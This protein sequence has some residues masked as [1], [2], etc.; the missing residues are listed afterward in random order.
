MFREAHRRADDVDRAQAP[1]ERRRAWRRFL[2][3]ALVAL[4]EGVLRDGLIVAAVLFSLIVAAAGATSGNAAWAVMCVAAGA[5][6]TVLVLVA[7]ARHWA[8][9]RQWAVI[10]GVMLGQALLATL[11]WTR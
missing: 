10:L 1:E 5:L 11:F 6:G 3:P 4:A 9:G 2:L 7:V 8:F